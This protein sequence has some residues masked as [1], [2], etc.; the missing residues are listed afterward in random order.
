MFL[1]Q[2]PLHDNFGMID[3]HSPTVQGFHS[4]GIGRHP[5]HAQVSITSQRNGH[6][7]KGIEVRQPFKVSL[8]TETPLFEQFDV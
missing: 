3:D 7:V 4:N 1:P 8:E 2:K 5:V 6:L